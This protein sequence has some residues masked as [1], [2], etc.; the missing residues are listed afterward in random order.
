[1]IFW[2]CLLYALYGLG[3]GCYW[4]LTDSINQA[5]CDALQEVPA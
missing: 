3:L 1:M 4:S 5:L 2:L